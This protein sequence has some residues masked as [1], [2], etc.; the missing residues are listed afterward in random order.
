MATSTKANPTSHI[1]I[2]A[3]PHRSNYTSQS[4]SQHTPVALSQL[5]S[6][7]PA[8]TSSPTGSFSSTSTVDLERATNHG[9][10]SDCTNFLE[11]AYTPC[12]ARQPG[13]PRRQTGFT[14]HFFSRAKASN[15]SS[16]VRRK[17]IFG[18]RT[19]IKPLKP[20]DT[21][22]KMGLA[23][24]HAPRHSW[25]SSA[26][27]L[28]LVFHRW[29]NTED[30]SALN[31]IFNHIMGWN[32]KDSTIVAQFWDMKGDGPKACWEWDLV[33]DSVPFDDPIGQFMGYRQISQCIP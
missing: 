26:R 7:P 6:S 21:L 27:Q 31:I 10:A 20:K 11:T 18:K 32:M 9:Y 29:Y 25:S 15:R 30:R 17:L 22:S 3:T 8:P 1:E 5:L 19:S 14:S 33:F 12:P 2:L 16:S 24:E 4:S 13:R 23:L 28:L